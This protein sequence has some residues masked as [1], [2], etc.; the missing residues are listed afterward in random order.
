MANPEHV[1]IVKAGAD[2]IADWRKKNPE[3]TLDLE[4]AHIMRV[5]LWLADLR[6]ANLARVEMEQSDLRDANLAGADFSG[7]NLAASDLTF[8]RLDGA[9]L[10]RQTLGLPISL[11]PQYPTWISK[12]QFFRSPSSAVWI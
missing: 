9:N 10:Q 11:Q 5:D 2:A 12:G 6:G 8:A 7:A 4:G 1:E 3:V